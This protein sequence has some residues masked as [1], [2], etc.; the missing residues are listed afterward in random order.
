MA[1]LESLPPDVAALLSRVKKPAPLESGRADAL[2]SRLAL[3]LAASHALEGSLAAKT[4]GAT[5]F[6]KLVAFLTRK[7][8]IA[9]GMLGLGIGTGAV[10]HAVATPKVSPAEVTSEAR[11]FASAPRAAIEPPVLA[12]P[13]ASVSAAFVPP[14]T[15]V[16]T[17]APSATK[18]PASSLAEERALLE[19]GRS[20]LARGQSADAVAAARKH[21]RTFPRGKL[22]EEREVLMVQALAASGARDEAKARAARFAQSYPSSIFGPAVR[23]AASP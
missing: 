13:T 11:V 18:D 4:L 14:A 22:T 2:E 8:T 5:A 10:L 9:I 21:E 12:S 23:A 15:A 6:A 3:A 7:A 20:A 19:M 17:A 1:E 16:S